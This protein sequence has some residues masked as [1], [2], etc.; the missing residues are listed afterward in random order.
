LEKEMSY[1]E[2]QSSFIVRIWWE[3]DAEGGRFFLRGRVE[4]AQTGELFYF[5][6][7]EVLF[8]FLLKRLREPSE[9]G[10]DE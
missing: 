2:K 10:T 4:D 6:E 5:E 8:D 9:S 3:H 1:H 7:P